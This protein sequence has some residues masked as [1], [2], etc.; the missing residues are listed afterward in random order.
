M[1]EPLGAGEYLWT[2]PLGYQYL[3]DSQGISRC[4][5]LVEHPLYEVLLRRTDG[6]RHLAPSTA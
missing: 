5:D 3:V 1:V 6:G 2:S 4:T